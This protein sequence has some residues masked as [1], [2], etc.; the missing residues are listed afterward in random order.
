MLKREISP[1]I[2]VEIV[3]ALILI[4]MVA[5]FAVSGGSD[6]GRFAF[7]VVIV[8]FSLIACEM[9]RRGRL[10]P[11]DDSHPLRRLGFRERVLLLVAVFLGCAVAAVFVEGRPRVPLVF[12]A[13]LAAIQLV[14]L[15]RRRHQDGS[16]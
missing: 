5:G 10:A 9:R 3:F 7:G 16:G 15:A 13:A 11:D 1:L 4:V 6:P 8:G 2:V 14:I 12:F